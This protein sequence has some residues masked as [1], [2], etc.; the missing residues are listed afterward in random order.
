MDDLLEFIRDVADGRF[1]CQKEVEDSCR[2]IN[3]FQDDGS[4][5]RVGDFIIDLLDRHR[6]DYSL[7]TEESSSMAMI[8]GG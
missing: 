7:A 6:A 8:S 2:M 1:P 5:H 3:D 4:S